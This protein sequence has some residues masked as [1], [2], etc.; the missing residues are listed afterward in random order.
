MKYIKQLLFL[1]FVST[2][3][4]DQFSFQFNND[5]FAGTDQHFTNGVTISWLD[6]TFNQ[7]D[8]ST[9]KNPLKISEI[10]SNYN[11]GLSISQ[12]V[13]TPMDTTI[14]TPQYD[15]IPYAGY[16]ALSAYLFEWNANSFNEFRI[17]VGVVGE[18]ALGEQVQN[19]FHTLVGNEKLKGWDTQL[20]TQ[21]TIN[22]LFRHGDI[23]WKSHKNEGLSMDWFNHYGLNI[24]NFITDVFVGTMFRIG[25]NYIENFNAHYPY[26]R[27][28]A[29]LLQLAKH[30]RGIGW[31]LSA[32]LNGELLAYS[33]ILDKAKSEGYE[34]S[35][36]TFKAS[37][38][39]GIDIVYN[40]HK[41]TY[42]YQAQSADTYKQNSPIIFGG[43]MYSYQF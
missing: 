31:A 3:N 4:A 43:F 28:E 17:E 7:D 22:A 13:I 14:S 37:L 1:V 30:N 36:R 27:K 38:Y 11:F 5:F 8:N 2:L 29:T 12:I 9:D 26:L 19:G 10:N 15:D 33:H 6:D 24:G 34:T 21:Y 40:I 41:I 25:E 42:F 39:I 35:K 16:L 32:G 20:G 18:E 23:S